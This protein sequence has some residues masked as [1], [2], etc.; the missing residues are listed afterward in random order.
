MR[1]LTTGL[2]IAACAAALSSAALA[3]VRVPAIF[4]DDMVLQRGLPVPV[5]G[6]ASPGERVTVSF[7]AQEVAAPVGGRLSNL[8]HIVSSLSRPGWV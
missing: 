8:G 3:E 2:L 5:W 7:A 4:G 1:T 6:T